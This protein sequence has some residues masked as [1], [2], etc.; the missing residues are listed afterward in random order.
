MKTPNKILDLKWFQMEKKTI[1]DL[2]EYYNF[3]VILSQS[4]LIWRSYKFYC[5]APIFR[6]GH[7]GNSL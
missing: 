4:N 2:F 7:I 3:N 1:L 5:V 6:D